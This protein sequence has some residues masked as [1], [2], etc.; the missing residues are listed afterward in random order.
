MSK[1]SR[2]IK[3]GA[4]ALLPTIRSGDLIPIDEHGFWAGR[5]SPRRSLHRAAAQFDAMGGRVIVEIGTGI[6]GR[7][8]GD[9][10]RVWVSR[11]KAARIIAVDLDPAR[12]EEVKATLGDRPN[13]ELVVADGVVFLESFKEPIDLLYLDFWTP[14]PEGA[15]PGTGRAHAYRDAYAA[16]R[17][18]L[19]KRSMILIDDTDHIH[20]WKHTY[21][22]P[23]A[24][25]DGFRVIYTGRQTLLVRE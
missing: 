21:I 10:M 8:S 20:P 9:S 22:V 23:N 14:D 24:R 3:S 1:L 25:Q 11:T 2:R 17:E 18:R 12:T 6:H 7:M 4:R 16:A 15:L 13:L 5:S 19:N